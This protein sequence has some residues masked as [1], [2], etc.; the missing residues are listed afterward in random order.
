MEAFKVGEEKPI[1]ATALVQNYTAPSTNGMAQ[2]SGSWKN[3]KKK[4]QLHS[5]VYQKDRFAAGVC[6]LRHCRH[7]R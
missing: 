5:T 4:N 2:D 7:V 3:V 6:M 1:G